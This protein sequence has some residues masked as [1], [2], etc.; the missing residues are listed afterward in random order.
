MLP[1]SQIGYKV[2]KSLQAVL[3]YESNETY[4]SKNNDGRI[5]NLHLLDID[6]R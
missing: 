1:V 4:R 3:K 5:E 2:L 6:L